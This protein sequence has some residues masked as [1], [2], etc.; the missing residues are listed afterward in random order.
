LL[1]SAWIRAKNIPYAIT[2][3]EEAWQLRPNDADTGLQLYELLRK[4][5]RL[6]DAQ[7][8]LQRL[9]SSKMLSNAN[10][11]RVAAALADGGQTQRAI[12]LL[13]DVRP[14]LADAIS[15]NLLARL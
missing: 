10:R 11:V 14:G 9:A 7:T 15:D 12:D 5:G 1:A 2:Q 6:D 3:L 13:K 8:Y 4:Q